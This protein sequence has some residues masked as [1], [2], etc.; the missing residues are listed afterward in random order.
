[1]GRLTVMPAWPIVM[2]FKGTIDFYYW[3]GIPCF[4]KWPTW[5]VRTPTSLEAANQSRFAYAN[6]AASALPSEVRDAWKEMAQGT[7]YRWND[8]FVRAYMRGEIWE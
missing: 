3:K 2:G 7:P 8:L 5:K 1:M 4:R 6:K